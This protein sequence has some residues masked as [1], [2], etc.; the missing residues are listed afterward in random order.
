MYDMR[1]LNRQ[2]RFKRR[3]ELLA[4]LPTNYSVV[5]V[6]LNTTLI[7]VLEQSMRRSTAAP[8]FLAQ[9]FHCPRVSPGNV[10]LT[11]EPV[12]SGYEIAF[13]AV[14]FGMSRN[15]GEHRCVT[16]QETAAKETSPSSSLLNLG[17]FSD[18]LACLRS[19]L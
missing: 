18:P 6:V 11:K 12:D 13:T 16:S 9:K 14:F 10:P 5:S 17:L 19:F 1:S 15:D 7:S 3:R 4:I 2:D 8:R